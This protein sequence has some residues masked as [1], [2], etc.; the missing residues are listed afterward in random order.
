MPKAWIYT[1][2]LLAG[3]WGCKKESNTMVFE[4]VTTE[5]GI[6]FKYTFGDNSYENIME[7]SGSGV[8]ILDYDQDGFYDI[9]LLN[10]TYLEGISRPDGKDNINSTNKLFR[11]NGN[12]SF[13]D[14]SRQA[15]VDN[16]QWSMAAGIS[17]FDA[18][19]DPDIYLANYGP[20]VFYLNN[21][22]GTFTDVTE[23]LGLAG[24]QILN[25]FTKW[26]VS[27]AFLDYN[28][29]R[30]TDIVLGNFL[31]FDPDHGST[32]DPSIMPHPSEYH[33]QATLLYEQKRDGAFTA[34]T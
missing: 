20:N 18:D 7:S 24:P 28:H 13:S 9:Y 10:G 2:L 12:G 34:V 31:A 22:D 27:V 33:G 5:S 23:R 32:P 6:D 4:N 11:N 29:D 17:D 21:G 19:G 1:F 26:S 8:S 15:G 30:L 14:V 25:G 3:L 16:R